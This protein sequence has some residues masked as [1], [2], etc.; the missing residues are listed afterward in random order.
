MTSFYLTPLGEEMA[1][2]SRILA[3]RIPWTE[4]AGGLQAMGSQRVGHDWVTKQVLCTELT[5]ESESPSVVSDSLYM[6]HTYTV[7]GILQARILEWVAFPF[8]KATSQPRDQTPFSCIAGRFFTS[9]A[10]REAWKVF[11]FFSK[12]W[13]FLKFLII[14]TILSYD[15]SEFPSHLGGMEFKFM[16]LWLRYYLHEV[17][18]SKLYMITPVLKKTHLVVN[19]HMVVEE[20]ARLCRRVGT[21]L[22]RSLMSLLGLFYLFS[23]SNFHAWIADKIWSLP[24]EL[25]I[26]FKSP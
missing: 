7:H 22:S 4:E 13:L 14:S 19:V 18:L 11:S 21:I 2:H 1:T 16:A 8:S 24:E 12:L 5:I 6:D 15:Y 23:N 3:W 9:W 20:H 25:A 26:V 10:T 17:I